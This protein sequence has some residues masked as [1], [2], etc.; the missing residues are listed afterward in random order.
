MKEDLRV[1]Q[2]PG[3]RKRRWFS[4]EDFDLILW[5]NE[6]DSYWGFELC[7]DKYYDERALIWR[8]SDGFQH[9]AVDDGERE[10]GRYKATPIIV[11]DGFVNIGRIHRELSHVCHDLP[12][13]VA[14]FVMSTL[15]THPDW[16]PGLP[17]V[18]V[19]K[20]R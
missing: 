11:A 16:H 13:D 19:H 3:E 12:A 17:G 2:I 9:V 14:D 18:T 20:K 6:D 7:Y 8:P 10:S 1:R 4:S 15:E 5:L